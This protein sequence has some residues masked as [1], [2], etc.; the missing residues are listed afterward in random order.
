MP[1]E[2][3]LQK[4]LTVNIK[5]E[6]KAKDR[7]QKE[8]CLSSLQQNDSLFMWEEPAETIVLF[9]DPDPDYGSQNDVNPDNKKQE[10]AKSQTEVPINCKS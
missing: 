10:E 1:K 9:S 5:K 3:D 7:S 2:D 8:T 4:M 6:D